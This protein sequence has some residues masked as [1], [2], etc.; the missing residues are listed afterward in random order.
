M[1]V[2]VRLL[3]LTLLGSLWSRVGHAEDA[4][5]PTAAIPV[6]LWLL[7]DSDAELLLRMQGQTADLPVLL[8]AEPAEGSARTS[9]SRLQQAADRAKA[10]VVMVYREPTPRGGHR[11]RLLHRDR[12]LSRDLGDRPSLDT[13]PLHASAAL[14]GAAVMVRSAVKALLSG[15]LLGDSI[16]AVLVGSEG[17]AG[18]P[19]RLAPA[20]LRGFFALL[21]WQVRVDGHSP[22]AAHDLGVSAGWTAERWLLRA[23][24]SLGIP[25]LL[26]D[27]RSTLALSRHQLGLGLAWVPWS[28]ARLRLQ[29]GLVASLCAFLRSTQDVDPLYDATPPRLLPALCITPQLGLWLRPAARLPL[30]AELALGADVLWGQPRLGYADGATFVERGTLWPVQPALSLAVL[31]LA[32]RRVVST[33]AAGTVQAAPVAARAG[34][35]AA[36]LGGGHVAANGGTVH[37]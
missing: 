15:E 17:D 25:A 22:H 26:Q 29:I 3:L 18:S 20:G 1:Q 34:A 28:N 14:E 32:A 21:A 12:V 16:D 30:F 33:P 4:P 13:A 37:D 35:R 27:D 10:G 7:Q 2:W 11:L 24:V 6:V 36:D 23:T 31:W 9:A 5:A 19:A 8:Q